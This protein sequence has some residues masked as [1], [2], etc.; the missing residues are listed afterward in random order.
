MKRETGW[1]VF[2]SYFGGGIGIKIPVFWLFQ[3]LDHLDKYIGVRFR[4]L[5]HIKACMHQLRG[6]LI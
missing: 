6:C 5:M 3:A 2:S 4:R 1:N